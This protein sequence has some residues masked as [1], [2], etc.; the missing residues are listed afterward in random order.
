MWKK[1]LPVIT[2]ILLALLFV[3]PSYAGTDANPG[4]IVINEIMQNPSAVSDTNG[5]WFEI[6]NVTGSDVDINGWTIKDDGSDN[7]VINNGGPLIVPAG[8]YLVLCRNA[9]SAVNGGVPCDYQYSSFLLS[10]SDDEVVLVDDGA[11]PEEIDRVNYDNG[12]TFPDPNG[13]SMAYGGPPDATTDPSVDNNNGARWRTSTSTFGAGDKGTPGAKNDDVLGPNAITFA[14]MKA[15]NG[16]SNGV[17]IALLVG[18]SV[19][20]FLGFWLRRRTTH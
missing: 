7:H 15:S 19:L 10:N 5:E 14:G 3:A 12:A 16:V 9:D 11:T 2:V 20:L 1:A 8:G 13:A 4:D 17:I 18:F 6:K